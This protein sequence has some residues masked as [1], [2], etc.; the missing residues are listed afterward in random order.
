MDISSLAFLIKRFP[1]IFISIR[2]RFRRIDAFFYIIMQEGIYMYLF[3]CEDSIDGIFTGVYDAFAS[4]Y[5]HA[6]IALTTY[7]P[8]NY[9]LFHQYIQVPV[10]NVKSEKVARTLQQRLGIEV[11]GELCQAACALTSKDSQTAPRS[12]ADS[13][14]RTIVLAFSLL[15]GSKVLNYL[16]E[17][18]V[19][20]V[21]QL[22]RATGNEAHHFLGF[23]RFQELEH[24]ILFAKIH[25]KNDVLPLLADHF[26]DRLPM[27]NFM[28]Y[29]ET[30]QKAALH[31][32]GAYFLITDTQ[33]LDESVL[34]CL[35]VDEIEYQ[36]LWRGFFESI[37]IEARKNPGLQNQNIPK[38]FQKDM[39]EFR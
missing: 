4:R 11:Y 12:K 3:I 16:G 39:A 22:C 2:H 20:H 9:T 31:K 28:I 17:P 25:P 27:E 38:H 33:S 6:N 21:F 19:N 8:E 13:I 14:Y 23:L 18:Y 32:K 36:K 26:A 37:T 15:D 29:D 34:T 10:D 1:R 24:G 5:G 7:E 30:H 35:S